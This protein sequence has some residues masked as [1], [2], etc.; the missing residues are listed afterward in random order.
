VL[1]ADKA[2]AAVQWLV[3]AGVVAVLAYLVRFLM[4]KSRGR[5]E[6]EL[7]ERRAWIDERVPSELRARPWISR[8]FYWS[9]FAVAVALSFLG[10]RYLGQG[11]GLAGWCVGLSPFL[12]VAYKRRAQA[13]ARVIDTVQARAPEMDNRELGRLVEG[14]ERE[15]GGRVKE[16]RALTEGRPYSE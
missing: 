15:Y 5:R 10:A 7:A 12:Y 16:L 1:A 13:R 11:G 14:L 6:A 9:G 4:L 8:G 2:P 3:T